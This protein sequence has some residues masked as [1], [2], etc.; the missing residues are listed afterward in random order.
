MADI[1]RLAT[2]NPQRGTEALEQLAESSRGW[3]RIQLAVLGFIGFCGVFW[4]GAGSGAPGAVRWLAAALVA[5][6]FVLA[7]LAIFMV[8]RVAHP[9]HG[10]TDPAGEANDTVI[11]SRT[12][13]L[14]TGIWLTYLALA[15]LVVATLSSWIPASSEGD[16]VASPDIGAVAVADAAGQSWCG[17]FIEA[18]PGG[19]LLHSADG[20]IPIPLD[21]VLLVHPQRVC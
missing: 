9:F 3:H 18:G 6:A 20:T 7:N 19:I 8:G 10:P 1:D 13:R 17:Q 15:L 4:N 12:H 21:G 14:R 16:A 11:V 2:D 5:V